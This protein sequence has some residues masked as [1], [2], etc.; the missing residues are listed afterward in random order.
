[1]SESIID[2]NKLREMV[3]EYEYPLPDDQLQI[4]HCALYDL[5]LNVAESYHKWCDYQ[6]TDASLQDWLKS[7]T[8]LHDMRDLI[9]CM[10]AGL[11]VDFL[12]QSHEAIQDCNMNEVCGVIFGGKIDFYDSG[13]QHFESNLIETIEDYFDCQK[14]KNENQRRTKMNEE[15]ILTTEEKDFIVETLRECLSPDTFYLPNNIAICRREGKLSSFPFTGCTPPYAADGLDEI[16]HVLSST[17]SYDPDDG[18]ELDDDQEPCN[19]DFICEMYME[20]CLN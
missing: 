8:H 1:M 19:V 12:G 4:M 7:R 5:H 15:M 10:V 3:N 11:E 20:R 6:G 13:L 9:I 2:K 18:E 17:S 16:I 14:T